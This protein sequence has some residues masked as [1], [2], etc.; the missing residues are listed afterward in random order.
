MHAFRACEALLPLHCRHVLLCLGLLRR[1]GTVCQASHA[2]HC[3]MSSHGQRCCAGK[4]QDVKEAAKTPGHHKRGW[5]ITLAVTAVAIGVY[6]VRCSHQGPHSILP[7]L[8]VWACCLCTRKCQKT[9]MLHH[10]E[11]CLHAYASSL[12]WAEPCLASNRPDHDFRHACDHPCTSVLICDDALCSNDMPSSTLWSPWCSRCWTPCPALTG[13]SSRSAMASTCPTCLKETRSPTQ[14]IDP[15]LGTGWK[16]THQHA[17][18]AFQD[19]TLP[20]ALTL[21]V[22]LPHAAWLDQASAQPP[23]SLNLR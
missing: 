2:P 3:G 8:P 16:T 1:Q 20:A 21:I 12:Q 13:P 6:L 4:A 17:W 10:A 23:N 9:H 7:V 19:A 22:T 5:G 15:D 11:L 14:V 18:H